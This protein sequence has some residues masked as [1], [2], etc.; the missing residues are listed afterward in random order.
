VTAETIADMLQARPTGHG[1]WI[2]RCP[3]HPDRRPSLSIGQGE[4]GKVLV[5]CW[6]GCSTGDVL[7]ALGLGWCDLFPTTQPVSLAERARIAEERHRREQLQR[8]H[9][10]R[11][12]DAAR[13]CRL[14][15]AVE[16]RLHAIAIRLPEDSDERL[17]AFQLWHQALMNERLAEAIWFSASGTR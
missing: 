5:R 1:R 15:G 3:A 12:R 7:R 10:A 14:W 8:E 6:T 16:S 2:A 17:R 13:Q 4:D 9:A 11:E